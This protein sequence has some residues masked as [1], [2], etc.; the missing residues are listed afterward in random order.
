MRIQRKACVTQAAGVGPR[1]KRQ[2]CGAESCSK[3]HRFP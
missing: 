2:G 3:S 1:L